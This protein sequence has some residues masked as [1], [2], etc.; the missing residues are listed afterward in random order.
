MPHSAPELH[1]KNYADRGG[2][3]RLRW[4]TLSK[5]IIILHV[6]LLVQNTSEIFS[7]SYNNR[8]Y[9]YV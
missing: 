8:S 3:Y 1:V 9:L 6:L 7:N 5:I 2:R 4:L